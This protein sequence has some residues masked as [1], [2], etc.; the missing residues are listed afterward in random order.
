MI[1]LKF[2]GRIPK[3]N[4]M[5]MARL[6]R[7]A[8]TVTPIRHRLFVYVA[9]AAAVESGETGQVGF[10]V[11]CIS[12]LRRDQTVTKPEIWIAGKPP[13]KRPESFLRHIFAHEL[14]HYEQYRDGKPLTERG[15]AVRTKTLVKRFN[16]PSHPTKAK[17]M[18][19]LTHQGSKIDE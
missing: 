4:R 9:P 13:T 14:A 8:A 18:T 7:D 3:A 11:L 15:V 16:I 17:A 5:A 6:A 2:I 10:G 1:V 19:Q 12:C